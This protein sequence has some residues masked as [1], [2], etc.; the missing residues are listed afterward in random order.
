MDVG[1]ANVKLLL[2]LIAPVTLLVTIFQLNILD[3]TFAAIMFHS[4][5]LT[6]GNCWK[7]Y[8]NCGL[9]AVCKTEK[10]RDLDL[11]ISGILLKNVT[12]KIKM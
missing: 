12:W 10:I 11:Y 6:S 2:Q 9:R 4:I 1:Q 3:I 5:L 8:G 7:F